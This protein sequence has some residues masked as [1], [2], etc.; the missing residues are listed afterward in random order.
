MNLGRAGRYKTDQQDRGA[1]SRFGPFPPLYCTFGL[2][3]GQK[4]K[5]TRTMVDALEHKLLQVSLRYI[6]SEEA[7]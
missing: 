2:N 1:T 6:S 5:I 4:R 3:L 7:E